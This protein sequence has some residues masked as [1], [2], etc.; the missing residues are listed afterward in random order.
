[1]A[2][3]SALGYDNL[4]KTNNA[5]A[6]NFNASEATIVSGASVSSKSGRP[7]GYLHPHS[8][9]LPSKSGGLSVYK[10][11]GL[12][13][14][15]DG[16]AVMGVNGEGAITITISI[17]GTGGLVVSANGTSTITLTMDGELIAVAPGSG[18]ATI[19]LS[20]TATLGALAG[21]FG[22]STATITGAL[23]SYAVGYLAGTSSSDAEF[24]PDNL[25]AAVWGAIAGD[26]NAAGTMGEKLN[27]AG[28]ASNPWT[29]VIESGYTAEEILRILLAVAAG[30]T[31]I[32]GSDVAFRD[33]ADTKDRVAASMTGSERTTVT[34]D[35]A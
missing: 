11:T 8:W 1:M 2:G 12:T 13:I 6:R 16:A 14:T 20:P 17:D 7:N 28:S 24:S 29:E 15:T 34:L 33:V 32:S 22:T 26:Y 18:T 9:A 25:A 23:A 5:T 3:A 21:L 19:S 31:S 35:G 10:E 4:I 30:K 27:D